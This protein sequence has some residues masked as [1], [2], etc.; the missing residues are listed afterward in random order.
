VLLPGF[1]PGFWYLSLIWANFLKFELKFF[2]WFRKNTLSNATSILS[3]RLGLVQLA[4]TR[5]VDYT[6]QILVPLSHYTFLL[7]TVFSILFFGWSNNDRL[8]QKENKIIFVAANP[9]TFLGFFPRF[10]CC[11][12]P[13]YRWS[14]K[15][16]SATNETTF[17]GDVFLFWSL[18]TGRLV[19]KWNF[20]KT[21]NFGQKMKFW[22]FWCLAEI[23]I[24]AGNFDFWR[25]FWFFVSIRAWVMY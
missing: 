25:K 13:W 21:W 17:Y 20:S 10:C 9:S 16:F 23:L 6:T 5:R 15:I 2:F 19:K 8:L 14:I 1:E 7:G 11:C 12:G 18:L 24:F 3:S 22:Q 4:D